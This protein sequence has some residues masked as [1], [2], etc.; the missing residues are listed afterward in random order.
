MIQDDPDA[1][2]L[3]EAGC[4]TAVERAVRRRQQLDDAVRAQGR[5]RHGVEAGEAQAD[6]VQVNTY[7][8][9]SQRRPVV[10]LGAVGGA[11]VV[12]DSK[13]S[14][15]TDSSANSIQGQ[16]Y[17]PNGLPVGGQ[18]QVN[19]YTT[20]TQVSPSVAV[21]AGGDFVVVWVSLGSG[22]T[23]SSYWSIQG[24]RF[25]SHGFPVGREFQVNTYTTSFQLRSSVAV[26]AG[27][28]F[29][30][31]WESLGSG[32]TDSDFFS[33]QGQRFASDGFPM[34]GE[35]QVNTYTTDWQF[36]PS[37]T[38]GANGDFLVVWDGTGSLSSSGIQG[39]RYA[40]DGSSVGGQFQV[41]TYTASSFR[42][43]VATDAGGE[44]V[45]V[46]ESS[47]SGGTDT[48]YTS[49][50]KTPAGQIFADGFES[51]GTTAWR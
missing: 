28:D 38:V 47:G 48:D 32:G 35:F 3:P 22:G 31:V 36:N 4:L 9:G 45:V 7:T 33:I 41:N 20:D 8:T 14:S 39:Q 51:G 15:G 46:W 29:I 16:R 49:V 18:F 42:P 43:S 11:V 12:W 1:G 6:D 2:G 19:T 34:G 5:R 21:D 30:A 40:S 24:Q 10:A 50:Q 25:A 44:L 27:G 37:V 13:G 17:A 23:D 26:D